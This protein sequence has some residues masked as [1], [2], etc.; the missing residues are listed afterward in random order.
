MF[1]LLNVLY[2]RSDS[3]LADHRVFKK[4]IIPENNGVIFGW[5]MF[6]LKVYRKLLNEWYFLGGT[7]D[8]FEIKNYCAF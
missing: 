7:E 6:C 1:K 8:N 4:A 2:E 5:R 3:D